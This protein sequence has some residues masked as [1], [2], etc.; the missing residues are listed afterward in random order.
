TITV[1]TSVSI[2][3]GDEARPAATTYDKELDRELTSQDFTVTYANNT[4]PGTATVSITG[5]GNY[6]TGTAIQK[7]FSVVV[8]ST[9]F[10][11]EITPV[12]KWAYGDTGATDI[13]VSGNSGIT[14]A[15]GTD[16]TLSISKDG[17]AEQSF[18]NTA[19]ALAYLDK[20]GT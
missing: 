14:L 11:M 2:S 12:T 7:T 13:T 9:T 3:V 18:T 17:G 8:T 20:P 1:P 10:S 5:T 19:D 4:S 6:Y 15:V 16:Y